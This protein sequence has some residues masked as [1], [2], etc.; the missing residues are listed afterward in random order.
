MGRK[1]RDSPS[2]E[3]Q[4]GSVARALLMCP[5]MTIEHLSETL[6]QT[7]VAC[8]SKVHSDEFG[9]GLYVAGANSSGFG[10]GYVGLLAAESRM[11]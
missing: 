1:R 3:G 8:C 2:A 9:D 6:S 10:L 5:G 4:R 11:P 7:H